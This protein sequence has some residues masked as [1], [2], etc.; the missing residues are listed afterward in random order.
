M[1]LAA[2]HPETRVHIGE[3]ARRCG[4]TVK[5]LR[6][7]E[8]QGL[9]PPA[10]RRGAYRTY[11]PQ[12]LQ[13]LGFLREARSFGFSVAELRTVMRDAFEPGHCERVY[14]LI[15]QRREQLREQ[16]RH[17]LEQV[18]ALDGLEQRLRSSA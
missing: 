13:L 3:A 10:Q 2:P 17:L 5:A 4:L 7:Y 14:A 8:A 6:F 15:G 1:P 11:G 9:I 18:E 12:E 16:A